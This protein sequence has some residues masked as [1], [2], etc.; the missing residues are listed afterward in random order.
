MNGM[1]KTNI[2]DAIYYTCIGKSY[3][4]NLDRHV[5]KQ[6]ESFFRIETLINEGENHEIVVIKSQESS[7]KEIEISGKKLLKLFARA[8]HY[9]S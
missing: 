5:I 3:F 6:G 4:N 2:L 8:A 9:T 7:K 1:G